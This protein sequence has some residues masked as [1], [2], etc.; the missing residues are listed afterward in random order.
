MT[1]SLRRRPVVALTALAAAALVLSPLSAAHSAD[2]QS[3]SLGNGDTFTV[4]AGVTSVFVELTGGDGG[5]AT[6][7]SGITQ[8]GQG[9]RG[10]LVSGTLAVEPG[11]ELS[12]LVAT[13]G[14]GID[15][16]APGDMLAGGTGHRFGG[17]GWA[18][19]GGSTSASLNGSIVA[20]A[21]GGGGGAAIWTTSDSLLFATDG[22]DGGESGGDVIDGA[23][24]VLAG[25]AAGGNT[26][27]F[28]E[29]GQSA[30]TS[31]SS[32]L[33]LAFGAGGAGW[34]GGAAGAND[35][36]SG[37]PIEVYLAGGG[38]G[39]PFVGPELASSTVGVKAS[40]EPRDGSAT[41]TFTVVPELAATGGAD[42]TAAAL[43]AALLLAVGAAAVIRTRRGQP[44]R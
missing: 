30:N 8:I 7:S 19:G 44:Q 25:G 16:T 1:T 35:F 13:A 21:P 20:G 41:I 36:G 43:A 17:E 15:L 32:S 4:P 27:G 31:N 26:V 11:D 24:V 42:L 40:A 6:S 38:G 12:F 34:P 5:T 33:V 10:G 9:G 22:G 23:T 2:S 37:T 28:T 3:V 14:S 39:L 18:S 29:D